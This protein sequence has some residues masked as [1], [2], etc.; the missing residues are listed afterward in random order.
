V[1]EQLLASYE[2]L[3]SLTLIFINYNDF[4]N[5]NGGNIQNN[6]SA[7]SLMKMYT[8]PCYNTGHINPYPANVENR[9]RS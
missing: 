6:Y 7:V 5:Y 4:D 3:F 1:A 8:I 2:G 9:V